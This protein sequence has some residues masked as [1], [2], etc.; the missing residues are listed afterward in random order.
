MPDRSR[1]KSPKTDKTILLVEDNE[2]DS[3]LVSEAL[4]LAGFVGRFDVLRDGK[5]AW[6]YVRRVG[7][8][9]GLAGT[10]WPNLIL[11]D[12]GMPRKSGMELL[13][14]L[15]KDKV[16]RVLPVVVFSSYVDPR[17]VTRAYA[18]GANAY[19]IKPANLSEFVEAVRAIEIFWGTVAEMPAPISILAD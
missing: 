17:E 13:K 19:V 18:L 7:A 16:L 14:D 11:L 12:L 6:D 15:K 3:R 8:Y 2:G 5:D 10:A 1:A 9:D 4:Q